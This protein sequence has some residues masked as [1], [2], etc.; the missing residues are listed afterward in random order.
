MSPFVSRGCKPKDY[1]VVNLQPLRLTG[2]R[3]QAAKQ[4]ITEFSLRRPLPPSE[5]QEA[6]GTNAE[7]DKGGRLGDGYWP[8][9]VC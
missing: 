7:E 1:H 4:P 5:G 8:C 2:S 6:E 3:T 9:Q